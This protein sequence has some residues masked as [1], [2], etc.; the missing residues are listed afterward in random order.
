MVK[1]CVKQ[2]KLN[3]AKQLLLFLIT[4]CDDGD[5]SRDVFCGNGDA[6]VLH[7]RWYS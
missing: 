7:L 4:V 1:T 3:L 6:P 5:V 2:K